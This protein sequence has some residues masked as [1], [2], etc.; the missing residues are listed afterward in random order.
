M[1]DAHELG[2]EDFFGGLDFGKG[3]GG[4]AEAACGELLVDDGVDEAGDVFFG[5]LL[6]AVAGG[7]D[8]V[9]H[10]EYG[11]LAGAG[12]GAWIGEEAGVEFLLGALVLGLDV[13]I[14]GHAGAVVGGDEAFDDGWELHA[15]GEGEAFGNVAYDDLGGLFVGE[16]VV[17]VDAVLVFGEED[18][19]AYLA[20][21][22]VEGSGTYDLGL[23]AYL[24]GYGGAEVGD[25]HAVLE[26]AGG[27]FAH[28]A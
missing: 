5:D 2:L 26:G 20:D 9:A 19:V 3:D 12:V 25:L 14:F 13:E 21:V 10:G 11:L 8:G 24:L 23:C 4:V 17:G 18:G 22:V 28:L 7:F 1:V 6:E 16:A 15:V 27:F